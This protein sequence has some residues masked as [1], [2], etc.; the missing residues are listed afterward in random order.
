MVFLRATSFKPKAASISLGVV[1]AFFSLFSILNSNAQVFDAERITAW[2]NAGLTTDLHAPTNQVNV[3]DF[4]ADNT[5]N[6]SCNSAYTAAL[7]SLNG[8]AG[9]VYF[10][11]GEYF[12]DAA[13]A[14]PDGVF[15]KGESA[16]SILRFDLGG[17][18]NLIV[19]NG[20]IYP[21][22]MTL[23][24]NAIKGSYTLELTDASTIT[25]GDVVRLY[26]FD[27][28]Y[29]FSS[30]A[31]GSLGQVAEVTEVN[32][33]T[34]TLA[35]PLNHHY[36][37]AR[38]PF[39]KKLAPR[40][41]AGIE[42]LKIVRED[43]SV[44]QTSNIYM[45]YAFNCAIRNVQ[46]ANSN[47]AHLEI[48]SSAHVQVEGCYFH[49][50]FA[51]GGGGQGYGLVFQ[52]ASSFCLGQ[53]NAF[54]HLRHSMLIQSGA[55]GN[56]FGYNYS[57]DAYWNESSFPTNASGDAVLHGNYT[58]LNL[59]EGNTVQNIVV[60]ASHAK[61]GPFNTFFRNRA[62]L[63]GFFS[64]SSTPT[65]SM[66]V[67]GN[68]ITNTGFPLGLFALNGNGHYS[69]GNN[70]YGTVTPAST[71]NLSVNSL[72]L[73]ES[74]LPDFLSAETLPMVGYPLDMNDK[75]LQA[76]IRFENGSPVSCSGELVT[77]VSSP[78]KS[79]EARVK[80]YGN[81]L[82]MDPSLLPASVN[83]YSMDGKL[84]H[85]SVSS[86]GVL[87][88]EEIS[89]EPVIVQVIGKNGSASTLKVLR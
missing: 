34:L 78:V 64:D 42:C 43:A 53:N 74:E 70:V 55:N 25:A 26:Q 28:D 36:P 19:M 77:E 12:F 29:M 73:N 60:D 41:D 80:L 89:Q 4:G 63:Y 20:S 50:A 85:H 81:E 84:L 10:P 1:L 72:Y 69:Y 49:R 52:V 75:L 32:G 38:N 65:D 88:L 40:R 11:Q 51:Y 57:Y 68:E 62:E 15:M 13:I 37:I 82:R 54:E 76:Q 87:L 30:W 23:A 8:G 7:A 14:V 61:N 24:A 48:N 2:E 17:S 44:G 35:D 67:V 31:H 66:N 39:L 58:Y 47:F 18:G 5:G 9:T 33:N 59:F 83:I 3:L 56:V 46:S 6:S 21:T 86:I 79:P 71:S 16:E 22:E 27:E 45:G